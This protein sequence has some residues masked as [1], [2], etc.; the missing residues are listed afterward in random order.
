M[1][2]KWGV[3][4]GFAMQEI[5]EQLWIMTGRSIEEDYPQDKDFDMSNYNITP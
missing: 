2:A 5:L 3:M 1:R 4:K